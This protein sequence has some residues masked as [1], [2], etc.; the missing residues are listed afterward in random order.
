MYLK[1]DGVAGILEEPTVQRI[2]P[3]RNWRSLLFA[4][5]RRCEQLLTASL[6]EPA[7]S[8]AAGLLFGSRQ[9]FSDAFLEALRRTNTLH[10][11]A[12][13]G[14]NITI[15][16]EF[17]RRLFSF[18]SR[19][20]TFVVSSIAITMFVMMI[21]APP[22]AV[23][24]GIMGV[25]LL[26]GRVIGRRPYVP[27]LVLL[28]ALLMAL[29]NPFILRYDLG[30]QLSFLAFM[31][32]VWLGPLFEKSLLMLPGAVRGL[33][34]STLGATVAT[35]P[36]L[37]SMTK[38]VSLVGPFVNLLILPII[39][40]LMLLSGLT[41]A[42][43]IISLGLGSVVGLLLFLP[44]HYLTTV[45]ERGAALP[46]ASTH[47]AIGITVFAVTSLLITLFRRRHAF[48]YKKG[49]LKSLER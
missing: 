36:V 27:S 32:L 3:G 26:L 19:R 4:L 6:P 24:A 30:F 5:K 46:L 15:L 25:A 40:L 33:A 37:I 12:V 35:A 14:F 9:V 31:G 8:L 23:R 11:I 2:I 10:I 18:L 20:T 13:S 42:A 38:V 48:S 41:L 43:S 7:S 44:S 16:A 45:V 1:A 22:S 28:T 49:V 47:W 17:F 34:A 21:G 39:P 29:P